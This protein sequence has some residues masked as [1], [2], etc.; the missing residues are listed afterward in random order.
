MDVTTNDCF[1][2]RGSGLVIAP[3]DRRSQIEGLSAA[4]T[5]LAFFGIFLAQN[6]K[7][8]FFLE[9]LAYLPNFSTLE[10]KPSL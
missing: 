8:V 2:R 1:F 7:R 9:G 10:S 5:S 6:Q 4:M 3:A